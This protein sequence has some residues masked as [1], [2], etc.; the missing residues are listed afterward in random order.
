MILLGNIQFNLVLIKRCEDAQ[1]FAG[2][3]IA[4]GY[5]PLINEVEIGANKGKWYRVSLGAFDTLDGAKSY[6]KAESSL[7]NSQE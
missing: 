5:K 6:V 2:G 3:F 7:F 1:Q 4:R